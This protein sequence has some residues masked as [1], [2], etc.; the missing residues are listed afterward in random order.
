MAERGRWLHERRWPEIRAHLERD[1]VAL[2]P[3]GSTEQHGR[4]LPVMT[5]AAEAIA[6]A[7]GAAARAG[8]LIAPP[9][10]YGWTAHHM[11]YPDAHPAGRDAHRRGRG[12]LA[13]ASSRASGG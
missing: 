8:V 4:H 9:L 2:L 12:R 6:V 3:V 7:V 11:A 1:D 13:R 5:D 10:W